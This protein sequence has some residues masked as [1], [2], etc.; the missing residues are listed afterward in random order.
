MLLCTMQSSSLMNS[1]PYHLNVYTR[2][3]VNACMCNIQSASTFL[4]CRSLSQSCTVQLVIFAGKN[5]CE[6][7][8]NLVFRKFDGFNFS[9]SM[10]PTCQLWLKAERMSRYVYREREMAISA[11][12]SSMVRKVALYPGRSQNPLSALHHCLFHAAVLTQHFNFLNGLSNSRQR[13][14]P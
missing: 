1:M 13:H 3:Y 7:G 2:A 10:N 4:M 5:L 9:Q 11:L 14:T 6:T 8:Q 12:C